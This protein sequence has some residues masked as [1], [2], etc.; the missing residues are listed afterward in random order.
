M[1]GNIGI[2][3]AGWLC[4]DMAFCD[5]SPFAHNMLVAIAFFAVFLSRLGLVMSVACSFY[6]GGF[7]GHCHCRALL[8]FLWV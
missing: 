7:V 3:W 2:I 6:R 8:S 1:G 5:D 4:K